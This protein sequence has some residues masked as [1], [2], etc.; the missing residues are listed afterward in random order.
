MDSKEKVPRISTKVLL[1]TP[2]IPLPLSNMNLTKQSHE[3]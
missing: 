1:K 3:R 2:V